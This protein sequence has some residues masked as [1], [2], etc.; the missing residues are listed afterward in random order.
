M[1]LGLVMIFIVPW[2]ALSGVGAV[3]LWVLF[4]DGSPVD[5]ASRRRSGNG[6]RK[7]W[8]LS[9]RPPIR[10]VLPTQL[11]RTATMLSSR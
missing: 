5:P 3:G 7:P 10:M 1:G 11:P 9:P 4:D 2:Q 8:P 6:T